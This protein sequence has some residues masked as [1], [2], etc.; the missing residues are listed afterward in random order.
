M[1]L[2]SVDPPLEFTTDQCHTLPLNCP[3]TLY[4][5]DGDND[6]DADAFT[7]I[8]HHLTLIKKTSGPTP[9]HKPKS[10]QAQTADVQADVQA[11]N[12]L[13]SPTTR[14][15]TATVT[16][17]NI[18]PT[19]TVK[20]NQNIGLKDCHLI[21]SISLDQYQHIL[22]RELFHLKPEVRGPLHQVDFLPDSPILLELGLQPYIFQDNDLDTLGEA[23]ISIA[24]KERAIALLSNLLNQLNTEENAE[25]TDNTDTDSSPQNLSLKSSQ[26]IQALL[27]DSLPTDPAPWQTTDGWLCRSVQQRQANET[28]G[29]ATLWAYATPEQ[30]EPVM[31]SGQSAL[32]AI[33]TLLQHTS[34]AVQS[35]LDQHLPQVKQSLSV[36]SDELII[37]LEQVDWETLLATDDEQLGEDEK[38]GDRPVSQIVKQF[39]DEDDWPYII[40]E[41]MEGVK[42]RSRGSEANSLASPNDFQEPRDLTPQHPNTPTPSPKPK[43][44]NPKLFQLAF[45]GDAGRWTCLAQT[46][47][48]AHQV[49]FY[50][51]CPISVPDDRYGS[52]AEFILRVNDSLLIGNFELDIDQGDIRYKTSLDTEGDR[53]TS[54]LM[55]RLVYANVH[56][57][58][59]Y[60]PGII[61]VL[62][63]DCSPVEAIASI[64]QTLESSHA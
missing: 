56:T 49:V 3:I 57:M 63:G 24:E 37:A 38:E 62:A 7:A 60:L 41:E 16:P 25:N 35:E 52:I 40:L 11:D 61:A 50:S 34:D 19:A 14:T 23:P 18:S 31:Q 5:P 9:R 59:T 17:T 58:D 22:D 27:T 51:L 12:Q 47:D 28:V 20:L 44:Q 46:D 6:A 55:Q 54:T 42:P 39:F 15:G 29:Y 32:E 26:F 4:C 10:P 33:A 53:L 48:T 2:S 21:L 64:E 36:F 8:A 1:L 43:I 30:T 45:Q 13:N